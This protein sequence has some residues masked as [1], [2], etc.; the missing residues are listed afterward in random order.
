MSSSVD[1]V[2]DVTCEEFEYV[3]VDWMHIKVVHSI[4]WDKPDQKQIYH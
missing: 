2:T 3:I 1:E 4:S